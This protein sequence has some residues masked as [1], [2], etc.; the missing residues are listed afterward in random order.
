MSR[1]VHSNISFDSAVVTDSTGPGCWQFSISNL[2]NRK[3]LM[4]RNI[5]SG[6]CVL[7]S[8]VRKQ[9]GSLATSLSITFW[10]SATGTALASSCILFSHLSWTI[11]FIDWWAHPLSD[12]GGKPLTSCTT[13]SSMKLQNLARDKRQLRTEPGLIS[14]SNSGLAHFF[15][16]LSLPSSKI[17]RKV[18]SFFS[19][20]K[21]LWIF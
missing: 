2:A 20:F 18:S 9:I 14:L 1:H 4:E 15:H 8:R 19:G 21:W 13:W 17:D 16:I 6:G 3:S 10:I 11:L 5:F 7:Y 12:I